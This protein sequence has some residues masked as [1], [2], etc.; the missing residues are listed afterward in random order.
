MDDSEDDD[1]PDEVWALEAERIQQEEADFREKYIVLQKRCGAANISC[2]LVDD[3][4]DFT[5][6][7]AIVSLPNGREKREVVLYSLDTLTRFLSV[8]FEK[9]V[10]LG[11]YQAC[12]SYK[13]GT[14]EVAIRPLGG[15]SAEGALLRLGGSDRSRREGMTLEPHSAENNSDIGL[16]IG[17]PSE[18]LCCLVGE[19]NPA[20]KMS[21]RLWNL[22]FPAGERSHI[23]AITYIERAAN[24]FF[25]DLDMTRSLALQLVKAPKPLRLQLVKKRQETSPFRFPMHEFETNPSSLYWYA[26]STTAMPLQ[27]FLAYYQVIEYYFPAYSHQDAQKRIRNL[28]KDPAFRFESDTDI[29]K[30]ISIAQAAHKDSRAERYQLTSTVRG[31]LA[32]D[33]LRRF[34]QEEEDRRK[35]LTSRDKLLKVDPLQLNRRGAPDTDLRDQVANRIYTIRCKIVHTKSTMEGA[36]EDAQLA[37]LFPFSPE[38]QALGFDIELVRYASQRVLIAASI[39]LKPLY[40]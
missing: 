38:A 35:F 11:D 16:A 25:M 19:D 8:E 34:L 12:C 13:E 14:V 18:E 31:C 36:D 5:G 24:A 1:I 15:S 6:Q 23:A 32:E 30:L 3:G 37:P 20:P 10:I 7:V 39:P 26:R 29:T 4:E 21:L 40:G 2:R 9:Y 28:L 33:D 27:Q 22:A 17:K